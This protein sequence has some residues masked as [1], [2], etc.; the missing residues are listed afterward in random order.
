MRKVWRGSPDNPEIIER[1]GEDMVFDIGPA[2]RDLGFSPTSL[3]RALQIRFT[4]RSGNT[5]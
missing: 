4:G 2:R 5:P 3:E 1:F